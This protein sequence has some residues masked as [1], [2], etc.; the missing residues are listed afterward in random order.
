LTQPQAKDADEAMELARMDIEERKAMTM[1][2]LDEIEGTSDQ[3]C[4]PCP[5]YADY[6][7]RHS[8]LFFYPENGELKELAIFDK[9]LE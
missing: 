3:T 7:R 1:E 6:R 2:G 9:L 8:K 4:K 5:T